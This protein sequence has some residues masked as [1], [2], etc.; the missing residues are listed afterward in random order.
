MGLSLTLNSSQVL[1]ML[2]NMD[3]NAPTDA[4]LQSWGQNAQELLQIEI[5][6]V[7]KRTQER[8]SGPYSTGT[9][10]SSV[11]GQAY[12][13]AKNG[14]LISVWFNPSPQYAQW[15][16]YYAPYQEGEPLGK[17]TY[18]RGMHRMLY[19]S[20]TADTDQITRWAVEHGQDGADSWVSSL[21]GE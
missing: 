13:N 5:A 1:D 10:A 7:T 8:T 3:P 6:N 14:T 19:D 12:D 2:A 18:T 21:G 16:R 4:V 20:Q 11:T 9:L 15:H 17:D